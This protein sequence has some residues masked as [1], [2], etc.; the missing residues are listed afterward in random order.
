[1]ISMKLHIFQQ[2]PGTVRFFDRSGDGDYFVAYNADA[3]LVAKEAY[4][5]EGV[6]KS[7]KYKDQGV[8]KTL[9]YVTL[10]RTTF[11]SFV[12]E[13]LLVRQYRVEVFVNE[14][15]TKSRIE[16]VPKYKVCFNR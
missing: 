14:S 4:K 10:N 5:T 1:M 9:E 13:L 11:E 16:W 7:C 6:L 2:S 3:K 8:G 15:K 12:R